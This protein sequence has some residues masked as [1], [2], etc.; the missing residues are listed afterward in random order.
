MM[1]FFQ[2]GSF[3]VLSLD[4]IQI[5]VSN[6]ALYPFLLPRRYILLWPS[7]PPRCVFYLYPV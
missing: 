5:S 4:L 7:F 2:L 3:A 1:L 6:V